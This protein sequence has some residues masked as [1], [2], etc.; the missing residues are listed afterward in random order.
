MHRIPT[1][2]F[3][4]VFIH[5]KH[6]SVTAKAKTTGILHLQWRILSLHLW[7]KLAF[8]LKLNLVT[9]I[10]VYFGDINITRHTNCFSFY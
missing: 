7:N 6:K 8:H 3:V 5:C 1:P 10:F 4:S 2:P 9:T